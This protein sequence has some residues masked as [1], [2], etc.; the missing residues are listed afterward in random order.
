M[1]KIVGCWLLIRLLSNYRTSTYLSKCHINSD[2]WYRTFPTIEVFKH[3]T[4]ISC[5]KLNLIES[6]YE[7]IPS[8]FSAAM[9][10]K[11]EIW[12]HIVCLLLS[13][14]IYLCEKAIFLT[15]FLLETF[16][17]SDGIFDAIR[18]RFLEFT[19]KLLYHIT[20]VYWRVCHN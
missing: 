3:I 18:F 8:I 7:K 2:C 9:V 19:V 5:E 13:R 4:N 17:N 10:Q 12:R 16:S 11:L 1:P 15:Y 6:K 14:E 20:S